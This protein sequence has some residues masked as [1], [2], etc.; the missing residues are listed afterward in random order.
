MEIFVRGEN[1]KVTKNYEL[2]ISKNCKHAT[3]S[4]IYKDEY[5]NRIVEFINKNK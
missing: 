4:F 1:V 5:F 2:W 3:T